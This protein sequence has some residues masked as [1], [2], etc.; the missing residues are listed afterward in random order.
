MDMCRWMDVRAR[1]LGIVETKL[2]QGAAMA[3]I[4]WI[5]KL[6]PRILAPDAWVFAALALL[7]AAWPVVVFWRP[8]R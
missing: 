3:L 7:L 2:V 8:D 6:E 1:R 4:L 5:A